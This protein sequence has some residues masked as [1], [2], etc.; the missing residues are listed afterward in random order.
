MNE[1]NKNVT[2]IIYKICQATVGFDLSSVESMTEEELFEYRLK[3]VTIDENDNE[4]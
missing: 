4:V 3:Y 2:N 1:L